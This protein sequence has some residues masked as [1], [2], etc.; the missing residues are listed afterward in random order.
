MSCGN[1]WGRILQAEHILLYILMVS[2]FFSKSENIAHCCMWKGEM[3]THPPILWMEAWNDGAILQSKSY[4]WVKLHLHM[5]RG[6]GI[7]LL[8]G[9]FRESRTQVS[10]VTYMANLF[11]KC[12]CKKKR[13]KKYVWQWDGRANLSVS[14]RKLDKLNRKWFSQWSRIIVRRNKLD[15]LEE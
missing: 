14:T 10:Q 5:S 11:I 2:R 12:G 4:Y 3:R 6:P 9:Y 7:L 1:C 15:D 13:R 8:G